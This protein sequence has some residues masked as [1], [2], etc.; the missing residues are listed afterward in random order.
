MLTL[1]SMIK[2]WRQ[3]DVNSKAQIVNNQ[4][5]GQLII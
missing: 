4:L 3:T 2:M 5:F 1:K